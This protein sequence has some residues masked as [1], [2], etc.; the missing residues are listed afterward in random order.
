[1]NTKETDWYT[2]LQSDTQ[3]WLGEIKKLMVEQGVNVTLD[4]LERL[5]FN[6]SEVREALSG[7]THVTCEDWYDTGYALGRARGWNDC[8]D[9]IKNYWRDKAMI[10]F[11]AGTVLGVAIWSALS[12]MKEL[13]RIWMMDKMTE[14]IQMTEL[15]KMRRIEKEEKHDDDEGRN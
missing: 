15:M 14:K 10:E 5:R 13:W 8:L 6:E 7:L 12:M 4:E 3:Y 1:M 11:W 9:E 2:A